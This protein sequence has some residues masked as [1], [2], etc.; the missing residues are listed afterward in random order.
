MA[1][2][3]VSCKTAFTNSLDNGN[4]EWVTRWRKRLTMLVELI[5]HGNGID[6]GPRTCDDVSVE[7]SA[8]RF[9]VSFHHMNSDG[10][11]VGWTEH[12]VTIRPAF[13]GV[14]VQ[15]S[16]RNRRDVKD[17]LHE[18][19]EHAFTRHVTWDESAQRWTV[20]SDDERYAAQ[21]RAYP[22]YC[23]NP[24]CPKLIDDDACHVDGA[25]E[26]RPGKAPRGF[27]DW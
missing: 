15:I 13:D 1:A 4:G 8:I 9:S 19:M 21:A 7:P 10:F 11:Y 24:E 20:E 23:R 27:A 2:A 12:D 26:R 22:D 16:G 18:V 25:C 6:I 17:H 3:F 14:D 5:P